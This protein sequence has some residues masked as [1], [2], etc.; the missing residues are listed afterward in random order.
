MSK[1]KMDKIYETL[2]KSKALNDAITL[3]KWDLETEAPK[4][5]IER[6]S[7]SM[8]YLIGENYSVLINKDFKN[9]VYDIDEENLDELEKKIIREVKKEVFEKMEKIPKE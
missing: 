8:G 3:F 2:K 7:E 1:E 6:I 5:A 4:K 9:L